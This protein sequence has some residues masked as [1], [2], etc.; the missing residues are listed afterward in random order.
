MTKFTVT[1]DIYVSTFDSYDWA[2]LLSDNLTRDG[3][4]NF[5]TAILPDGTDIKL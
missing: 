1:H 3:I 4:P 2:K 5:I